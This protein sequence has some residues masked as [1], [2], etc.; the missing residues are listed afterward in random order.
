MKGIAQFLTMLLLYLLL[1]E[2][3]LISDRTVLDKMMI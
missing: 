3:L 1:G 2:V